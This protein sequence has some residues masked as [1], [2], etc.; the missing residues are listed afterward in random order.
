MLIPLV[1]VAVLVL[2]ARGVVDFDSVADQLRSTA[3]SEVA[4]ADV[5]PPSVNEPGQEITPIEEG[6]WRRR[7]ETY[8]AQVKR[9]AEELVRREVAVTARENSEKTVAAALS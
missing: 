6:I 8:E 1:A 5:D 7:L 9:S 3:V 2:Q 4:E